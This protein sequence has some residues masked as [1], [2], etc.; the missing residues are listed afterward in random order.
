MGA[1]VLEA[2]SPYRPSNG[3]EGMMFYEMWCARCSRDAAFENAPGKGCK[4]IS[5]SL[6]YDIGEPGYP[7]E[8]VRRANDDEWPGSAR[9]TAFTPRE[10]LVARAKRAWETRRARLRESCNDLFGGNP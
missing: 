9:C 1:K 10:E 4:I 8:W 7:K 2:W 3:T 6:L 5:R